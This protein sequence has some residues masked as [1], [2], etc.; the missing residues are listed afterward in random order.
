[1]NFISK[2]EICMVKLLRDFKLKKK[3]KKTRAYVYSSSLFRPSGMFVR[4]SF[5][6]I[7][8]C[9]TFQAFIGVIFFFCAD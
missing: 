7:L 1:M 3:T 5:M 8:F 2:L 4:F 9:C 6:A